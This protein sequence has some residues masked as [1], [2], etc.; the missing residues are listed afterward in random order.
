VLAANATVR[1]REGI[2]GGEA[3]STPPARASSTATRDVRELSR[4]VHAPL[5]IPSSA[6]NAR[7]RDFA[8]A[9]RGS[10]GAAVALRGAPRRARPLD[11]IAAT[12]NLT[13]MKLLVV[14]DAP[15]TA[16]FLTK[17]LSQCGFVV[18]VAADGDTAVQ[19]G[20]SV[21][22]DAMVID[23]M[24]PQRDGF[25]VLADLRGRGVQ[26][27][28]LFL[29]ARGTID[30]RVRGFEIGADDY[31]V[32]P[33]VIS[34]LV[35]RIRAILRRPATIQPECL[36]IADLE[37]DPPRRRVTRGGAPLALTP[38]EFS[39]LWLLARH[40]GQVLSRTTIAERVWNVNYDCETNVVDVHIRRLRAK[41]D[42]PF[43]QKLIHTVRGVGYVL[44]ERT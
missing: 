28:A 35:A 23:V 39:L 16:S 38:K 2:I 8:K 33:F 26:T 18:D 9:G 31:L 12:H 29:T 1:E 30:D 27:P 4:D 13:A 42:D 40:R 32:K 25:A 10:I 22:Y 14:E 17:G 44:E 36:V 43:P 37:I 34:E 6:R 41:A 3:R 21:S 24:L 11:R 19:L 15:K 7:R 5:S 20:T